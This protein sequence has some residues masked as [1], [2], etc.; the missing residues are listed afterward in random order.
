M[1]DVEYFSTLQQIAKMHKMQSRQNAILDGIRQFDPDFKPPPVVVSRNTDGSEAF[2]RSLYSTLNTMR[3]LHKP[4]E[5][6][7]YEDLSAVLANTG[8]HAH[9]INQNGAYNS[10]IPRNDGLAIAMK[11]NAITDVGSP[12]YEFHRSMESFWS[13]YRKTG[14][15]YFTRP[16]N[17]K[18]GEALKRALVASGYSRDQA[19]ELGRQAQV[20]REAY[21]IRQSRTV[22]EIPKSLNQKGG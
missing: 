3:S 19:T 16:T 10:I 8:L 2:T 15:L 20:Q 5:T 17:Q 21:G 12:H 9:H 22:P 13:Q 11:G 7:R 1:S 6:S 4:I 18:Y 14:A